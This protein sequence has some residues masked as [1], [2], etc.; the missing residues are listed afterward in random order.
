MLGH[1]HE[2]LA[3]NRALPWPTIAKKLLGVLPLASWNDRFSG[4]L[5]TVQTLKYFAGHHHPRDRNL[6][7]GPVCPPWKSFV[8]FETQVGT[9]SPKKTYKKLKISCSSSPMKMSKSE[10]A[11]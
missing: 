8:P 1:L 5:V 10:R 2:R 7:D 11:S 9:H 6:C 3:K 4:P